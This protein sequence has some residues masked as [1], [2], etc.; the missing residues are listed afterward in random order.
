MHALVTF[1]PALLLPTYLPFMPCLCWQT[2]KHGRLVVFN[3]LPPHSLL[4]QDSLFL[5]HTLP[6]SPYPPPFLSQPLW[7]HGPLSHVIWV[8]ERSIYL[9]NTTTCGLT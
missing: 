3:S 4:G 6:L 9:S 2:P 7:Q 1:L 5:P 8:F